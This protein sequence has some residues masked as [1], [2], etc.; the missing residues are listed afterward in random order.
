MLLTKPRILKV[1]SSSYHYYMSEIW[2]EDSGQ[3]TKQC[4]IFFKISYIHS[5]TWCETIY[6]SD[7]NLKISRP[8]KKLN[9]S[10]TQHRSRILLD[11]QK[12]NDDSPQSYKN[13]HTKNTRQSKTAQDKSLGSIQEN[14]G[15]GPDKRRDVKI[16]F[17]I[18]SWRTTMDH[19]IW[20]LFFFVSLSV[21]SLILYY[22]TYYS[23]AY[24]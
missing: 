14:S 16:S 10:T 23:N 6:I 15:R 13:T 17:I 21:V 1:R 4:E 18:H 3:N 7:K 12:P 5:R 11:V 22:N 20:C 24:G 9:P 19:V 8:L 2:N